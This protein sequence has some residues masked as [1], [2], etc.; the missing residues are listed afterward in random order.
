MPNLIIRDLG[1]VG[2]VTDANPYDLPSNAFS[3]CN[4]VIFDEGRVQRSPVFKQLYPAARSSL[5]FAAASGT[6]ADNSNTFENAQGGAVDSVRF[7]GSYADPSAGEVVFVCDNDSTIRAYPNGTLVFQTPTT[8]VVTNEEPWTH[9]QVAGLS[10]LARKGMHPY[11]RNLSSGTVYS[12]TFGDWGTNDTAAVVRSYLDFIITLNI[13]KSTTE[14]PTMVKWCDPVQYGQSLSTLK[15]DP[16]DTTSSAGENII[17]EL[18]TGIRDGLVLGNSFVI[19]AQDQVWLMEFTGSS[20][21]FNFR[22]LFPSGGVINTNCVVEVEG[23]HFVFGEDDIYLHDGVNRKSIADKRVRRKVFQALDRT[24]RKRFFV[25]H[26]SVSNLIYFNYATVADEANFRGT[27]FCNRS[28]IYNYRED[29][30]SFMDLPNVAGGAEANITLSTN[31]YDQDLGSYSSYNTGYTS[32]ETTTPKLPI[33]LGVTDTGNSLTE[34]RVYALDLPTIGVVN[35]PAHVE[36]L[37]EAFVERIGIDLDESG[38]PLRQYKMIK[39]IVPQAEFATS[40]QTLSFKVGS[41][42]LPGADTVWRTTYEYKPSEQYKIDTNAA[43][44]Y[45]AYRLSMN[46]VVNFKFSGFDVEVQP[47]SRR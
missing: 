15:W 25:T 9:S 23:K 6:F 18:K 27:S 13:T 36:T 4:N 46:D 41:S 3:N 1:A 24:R 14:Y 10:I 22:R 19:Y 21:V 16:A 33:M 47:L 31:Q 2:V 32:F 30:W 34:S 20:A 17:A 5:T 29:T 28:A 11:A 38:S 7:V 8:G 39:S 42:D 26:D 43:G 12:T 40:D 45:L 37:K 35:L 44:R